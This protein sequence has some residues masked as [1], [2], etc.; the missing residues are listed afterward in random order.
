M[1]QST[2]GGS[3]GLSVASGS[4]GS[5]MIAAIVWA[6]VSRRNAWRQLA[7]SYRI[8]PSVNW[9]ERKSTARPA[10]CSG[11]MYPAVPSTVPIAVCGEGDSGQVAAPES[12]QTSPAPGARPSSLRSLARPKSRIFKKP[13]LVSIRFSGLRSRCTMPAEWALARP[14][15]ACVAISSSRRVGHGRPSWAS[16]SPRSVWPSTT[17]H[18]DVRQAGGLADLV[19]RDDV[20]V[21]ERG[22]RA[23]LLSESSEAH[24][25][26]REAFGQELDRHVPVQVLVARAPD[27]SH[28]AGAQAGDELE[29]REPH[30]GEGRQSMPPERSSPRATA[31]E[32]TLRSI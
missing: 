32:T 2:G 25:I 24:W 28:P 23:R 29:A 11:D 22:G 18:H 13:S 30:A 27:V 14:S 19:D 3:A 7:S 9:S 20:R 15:A 16:S 1:I 5:S 12:N 6:G 4:G 8:A 17:L 21:I 10:A 26:R 31:A